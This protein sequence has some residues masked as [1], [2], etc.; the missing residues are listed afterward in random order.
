MYEHIQ[1]RRNNNN[2]VIN[3]Y[4]EKPHIKIIWALKAEKRSGKI[5]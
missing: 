3:T 2:E 5:D 4:P 1:S